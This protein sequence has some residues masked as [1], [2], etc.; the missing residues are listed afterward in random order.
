MIT[1]YWIEVDTASD[2]HPSVEACSKVRSK[3]GLSW[4]RAGSSPDRPEE[5]I[6]RHPP[7]SSSSAP[8][9][10]G[11]LS[12]SSC[13][14]LTSGWPIGRYWSRPP[15][16][17]RRYSPNTNRCLKPGPSP[18]QP[19]PLKPRFIVFLPLDVC[20][21][22]HFCTIGA[23]QLAEMCT[24]CMRM[25]I[26]LDFPTGFT[27]AGNVDSPSV[28]PSRRPPPEPVPFP[29][30]S[31]RRAPVVFPEHELRRSC[32]LLAG[33]SVAAILLLCVANSAESGSWKGTQPPPGALPYTRY[34]DN[35]LSMR[36]P[37]I[38]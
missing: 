19:R 34:P 23:A 2:P 38:I 11:N 13:A 24:I 20:R 37:T 32:V 29:A 33:G 10:I 3:G 17:N 27:N 22:I 15:G 30:V 8:A 35:P 12:G 1:F 18:T 16:P 7:P 14:C 5:P 25:S 6:G 31:R 36:E 26:E 9:L 21:T 4:C 28:P